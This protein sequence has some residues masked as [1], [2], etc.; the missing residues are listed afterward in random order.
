MFHFLD[1]LLMPSAKSSDHFLRR[2][3]DLDSSSANNLPPHWRSIRFA[4][5]G[6]LAGTF[7]GYLLA[8]LIVGHPWGEE[9]PRT[10][11]IEWLG[12]ML[13]GGILGTHVADVLNKSVGRRQ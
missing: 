10:W 3:G 12:I 9:V 5:L 13:L 6:S 1:K 11:Q 8:K 2:L 7:V 4:I